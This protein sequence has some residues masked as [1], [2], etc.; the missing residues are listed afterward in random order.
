MHHVDPGHVLE[1]LARH[2][3][4]GADAGRGHVDLAGI[5]LG[6]GDELWKR[7]HRKRRI[8]D[9]H[10]GIAADAG[11]RRDG[12]GEV[13]AEVVIERR[14]DRVGE[15]G[16]QERVP[17]GRRVE[18]DLGREIA[19]RAGPVL[20]DEGLAEVIGEPLSDQPRQDVGRTARTEADDQPHR[21]GGIRLRRGGTR[22]GRKRGARGELQERATG[23]IHAIAWKD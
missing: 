12:T 4:R 17:V 19:A 9:H 23:K 5:G 13:E 16:Q 18:H 15:R 1:Q 14:V 22:A 10:V 3:R 20:Y 8:D 11:D 21:A 6:V 7:V 2:V